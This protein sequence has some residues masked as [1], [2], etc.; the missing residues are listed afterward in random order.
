MDNSVNK[1][2]AMQYM[3][4]FDELWKE[5]YIA[6]YFKEVAINNRLRFLERKYFKN[7]LPYEAKLKILDIEKKQLKQL[8]NFFV[9][10]P[11]SSFKI[12][13]NSLTS[14]TVRFTNCSAKAFKSAILIVI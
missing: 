5:N 1:V 8:S 7:N 2:E 3:T 9:L 12:C 4:K 13:A 10:A 14:F 6:G 11:Y